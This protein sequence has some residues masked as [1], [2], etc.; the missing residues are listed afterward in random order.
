MQ[1]HTHTH[2]HAHTHSETV[3]PKN[4]QTAIQTAH[5][6]PCIHCSMLLEMSDCCCCLKLGIRDL[7]MIKD[8]IYTCEPVMEE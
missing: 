2:T 8:V 4:R 3:C 5:T 7:D 1:I 6:L